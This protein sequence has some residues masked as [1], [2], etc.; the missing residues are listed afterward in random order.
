AASKILF[1][2]V[3]IQVPPNLNRETSEMFLLAGADDWGGVSP[4]SKDYVNPEAPWPEIEELKRITKN[5]GFILKE[6]LPVY[7]KFISE[8]YLSEKVLERVKIHLNTL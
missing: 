4:L 5:A 7:P 6:R 1:P 2:D 8:E 3:S